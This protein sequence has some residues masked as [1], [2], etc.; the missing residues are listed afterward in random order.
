MSLIIGTGKNRRHKKMLSQYDLTV[1][2]KP[3][4]NEYDRFTDALRQ[5]V[6]TPNSVVKERIAQEKKAK[7]SKPQPSSSDHASGDKG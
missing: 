1:K 6:Q 5:V 7:A 2:T 3:P 4:S